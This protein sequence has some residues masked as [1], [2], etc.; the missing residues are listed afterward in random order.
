MKSSLEQKKK[1]DD[2]KIP[3]RF[4]TGKH[5]KIGYILIE[6]LQGWE[7]TVKVSTE[8]FLKLVDRLAKIK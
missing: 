2:F 3:L 6:E 8:E 5:N 7:S 4:F 1:I